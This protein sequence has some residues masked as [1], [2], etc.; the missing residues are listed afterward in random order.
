LR[1]VSITLMLTIGIVGCKSKQYDVKPQASFDPVT[2]LVLN[3]SSFGVEADSF[4]SITANIDFVNDSGHCLVNYDNPQY[5]PFEYRLS[6][7]EISKL[8]Q[9]LKAK[10]IDQL[11]HKYSV[12][13]TDQP[14]S[15]LEIF[16]GSKV[17]LIED[18][19][20]Q[21]EYPLKEIYRIVYKL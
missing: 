9:L 11:K 3:L 20:L 19:G 7:T 14:T 17:F 1:L 18:Y 8:R 10:A 6:T 4:P 15:R 13:M 21:G 12:S 16:Q 5:K 2:K